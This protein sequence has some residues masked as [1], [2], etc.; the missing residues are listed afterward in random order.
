MSTKFAVVS[1]WAEDVLTCAHFY[2]DV[3]GLN[4]L[5][6]HAGCLHFDVNGIYL[7][8]IKGRPMPPQNPDPKRFPLFAI[9][10]NDLDEMMDR[11][12]AHHIP[13]PWGVEENSA[14][15]WM[16]FHDPAGNL[17]ELVQF[18]G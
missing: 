3:L 4:L 2:R 8:I 5:P 11:L 14:S 16:M 6:H 13:M 7:T 18:N 1:I 10:V 17:I 12:K 9:S 15:R